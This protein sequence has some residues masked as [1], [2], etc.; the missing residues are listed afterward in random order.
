MV[1]IV[2]AYMKTLYD[3]LD[4]ETIG[5]TMEEVE[6]LKTTTTWLI[7]NNTWPEE[8]TEGAIIGTVSQSPCS[9]VLMKRVIKAIEPH[10]PKC[11]DV[12]IQHYLWHPL[13]GINMHN[14]GNYIFG[15]T[16]YLTPRWN[17]NWGGL[18]VYTNSDGKNLKVTFPYFNSININDSITPHM[19]TTVSPLAPY[20]RY[21]L[22]IRGLK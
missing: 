15:A 8:L 16:I 20:P 14:D 13:S 7:S 22:Q 11:N 17:I 19:V 4:D 5:M 18:F 12:S 21:T 6:Y 1:V 10:I 9:E 2:T 3:F